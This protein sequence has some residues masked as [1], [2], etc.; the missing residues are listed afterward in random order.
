MEKDTTVAKKIAQ[1]R[2]SFEEAGKLLLKDAKTQI[3]AANTAIGEKGLFAAM[4]DGAQK[5]GHNAQAYV[6]AK[7]MQSL[8]WG[9]AAVTAAYVAHAYVKGH[10]K[11]A[12][13]AKWQNF[14][15]AQQRAALANSN[16]IA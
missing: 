4:G 13:E 7:P 10:N 8:G 11:K 6:K 5:L 14:V 15:T 3:G 12:E 16:G 1:S 2:R 9:A